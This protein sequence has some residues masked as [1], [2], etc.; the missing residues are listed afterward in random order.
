MEVWLQL[1]SKPRYRWVVVILRSSSCL[2][3]E[4]QEGGVQRWQN[5]SVHVFGVFT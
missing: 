4:V 3:G 2:C 5:D 1:G